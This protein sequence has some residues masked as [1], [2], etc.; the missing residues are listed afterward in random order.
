LQAQIGVVILHKFLVE[1]VIKMKKIAWGASL[2]LLT[3]FL[4]ACFALQA[5]EESSGTAVAPTIAAESPTAES[6]VEPTAVPEQEPAAQE[7]ESVV[8]ETA[9]PPTAEPI[10]EMVYEIDASRSEARFT[11]EEVL[12]GSDTTVVGVSSNLAGQIIFDMANPADA[13]MGEILINA[14]DFVTDNDFRN[15]AI[16]NEILLTNSFEFISFAPKE[17]VGLPEAAVVGESYDFQILGDLTIIG[18]TREATFDVTVTPLSATELQGL[19]FTVIFYEEF[20][21]TVPLSQFVTAVN[22]DVLLELDFTAVVPN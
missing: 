1:G 5:P 18:E 21:V 12:R 9:E 22:E 17:F 13:Q 16:A 10:G 3:L 4:S 20:G 19:A 2:L 7:S 14:R 15:R 6:V 11:I 8:E